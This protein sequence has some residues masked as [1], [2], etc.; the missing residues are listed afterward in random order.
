MRAHLP[1][2]LAIT[3]WDFSWYTR[4]GTGEPYADLDLAMREAVDRGYNAVRICA[5]P[6]HLAASGDGA[7]PPRLGISGLG[8]RDGGF[9]G[10]AT[11]WYDVRGGFAIDLRDRLL[12]LF[13]AA[14]R[15][16]VVVILSSWE[17]QQ[18]AAFAADPDWW[19]Y[20]AGV[21]HD[22][23]LHALADATGDLLDALEAAGHLERVAF[24]ELHNEVDFSGTPS[25]AEAVDD[26]LEALTLRHPTVPATVSY[27]KPPHLDLAGLPSRLA[28][29]Q[30][31]VYA[32]GV[33]EAL[34]DRIDVRETGSA[35]F[36]NSELR[37]LLREDAPSFAEYGRPEAWR[38]EATVIT[39]Q[40]LYTYD[41]ID[42]RRWDLWLYD[43][44]GDYRELM[45]REIRSR[46]QAIGAWSRRRDV[47][48]VIGEGWVGYTPLH[49]RFE[50]GPVG[51]DLAETGLRAAAAEGAWGAVPTSNAAPHHPMWADTA[52]QRRANA[53]I[54]G[55][56]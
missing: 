41:C 3:L 42:P 17:Y 53:I 32:Y 19:R 49:A 9:Y 25:A 13:D 6:M 7:L 54:L 39:D 28:V 22:E 46:V 29:G 31:H 4:A 16:E 36:P 18:S 52:W 20:L 12:R 50:D 15:H 23:R 56:A 37:A 24:V 44:Y 43:H 40:M 47:P 5:A 51:T 11:R 35:G 26:A 48:F 21:P 8:A 55:R 45:H 27:G 14:A 2:R 1:D 30:F 34:Q 33:L 10:D 38:L